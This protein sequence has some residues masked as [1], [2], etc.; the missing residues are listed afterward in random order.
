MA[1]EKRLGAGADGYG[2]P[3]LRR[4]TISQTGSCPAGEY[5]PLAVLEREGSSDCLC[6]QIEH[7]GSW[8]WESGNILGNGLYLQLTGPNGDQHAFEKVLEPGER[9]C[10]VPVAVECRT[11]VLTARSGY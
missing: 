7:N 2:M 6:W 10:S 11:R 4:L 1:S 5:A 3:L 8:G 9:F